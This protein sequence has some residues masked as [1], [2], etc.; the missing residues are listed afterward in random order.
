MLIVKIHVGDQAQDIIANLK[1][2]KEL[3]LNEEEL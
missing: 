2:N 3:G 1:K